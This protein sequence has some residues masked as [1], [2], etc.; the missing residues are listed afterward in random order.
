MTET[1]II[2]II[3]LNAP[4]ETV[5]REIR[6]A[7][8]TL[9]LLYVKNHGIPEHVSQ[10]CLAASAQFFALSHKAKM[11]LYQEDPVG[12]NS[13]YRPIGDSNIDHRNDGDAVEGL[14]VQSQQ[15]EDARPGNKWPEEVPGLRT[16]VLEY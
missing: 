16:A 6:R 8:E 11:K 9:G 5:V 12:V 3:D 1:T 4:R 13:G 7:C 15:H 2:P 14:S 10:N